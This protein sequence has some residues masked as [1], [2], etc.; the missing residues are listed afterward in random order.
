MHGEIPCHIVWLKRVSLKLN[1]IDRSE[2]PWYAEY[3]QIDEYISQAR[4]NN[5]TDEQIK[6]SLLQSGWKESQFASYFST[7]GSS[8]VPP[9]PPVASQNTMWDGFEHVLL[10]ISLYIMATSLTLILHFLVNKWLPQVSVDSYSSSRYDVNNYLLRG[11]ASALLVSFPLFAFFFSNA[12]RRTLKNPALQQVK[13]RHQ[14]TYI[15]LVI[16]FLV[17]ICYIISLI[18]NFLSGNVSL[19]FIVN[20]AVTVAVY[21]VIFIYYLLQVKESR[22]NNA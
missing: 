9:P 5:Q 19:N 3:M 17:V 4:K 20:F 18:F 6:Q 16:S 1:F 15:N 11:Y 7:S 2:F 14:L 22:Q 10:F 8:L 21:G 12:K 13:I